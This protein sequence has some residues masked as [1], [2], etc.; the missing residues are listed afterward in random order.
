METQTAIIE[1]ELK[2]R[3]RQ[4]GDEEAVIEETVPEKPEPGPLDQVIGLKTLDLTGKADM[5]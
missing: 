3:E 4:L 5:G 2:R 1:R